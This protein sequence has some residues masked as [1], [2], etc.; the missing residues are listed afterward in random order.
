MSATVDAN[1][2]LY[3]VNRDAEEFAVARELLAD[4]GS[5]PDIVYLF[6]PTVMGCLRISTH[7]GILPNPLAP[8][9]AEDLVG[10]LCARAHVRTPGE[11]TA[12]W[13]LY[14][15]TGDGPRG[16]DVP[17]A[18]LATLMRAHGVSVI[19]SRDRDFKRYEGI[20]MR[21]PFG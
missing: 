20:E 8:S 19:Y 16:N 6:W 15:A 4:L 18:H 12:F 14:R 17:D 5:G 9:A 2:M 1:V 11:T 21:D 7:P 13:D 3:S 10:R